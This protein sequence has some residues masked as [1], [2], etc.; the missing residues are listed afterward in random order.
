MISRGKK[1]MPD[2]CHRRHPFH[3]A[4]ALHLLRKL[5]VDISHIEI[6]AAGEYENY[7]GEV[8]SQEPAPETPLQKDTRIVLKVGYR[9]AVDLMPYQ[10]F[11]GL[12]GI[13]DR[14]SEWED[15]SRNL[16]A[17]FD[18]AFVRYFGATAYETLKFNFSFIDDEHLLRY[19]ELYDFAGVDI[20]DARTAER[21][22]SLMS[23][24]HIWAGNADMMGKV[25]GL[26]FGFEFKITES[27]PSRQQI[28]DS[29]QYKLGSKSG[30]LGQESIMGHSFVEC[31][32][33]YEVLIGIEDQ[34]NLRELLP[35]KSTRRKIEAVLDYCMPGNLDY[36]IKIKTREGQTTLGDKDKRGYLG[37][38]SYL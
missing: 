20:S 34:E 27:T 14:T 24:F 21:W 36:S 11:Y 9:S 4:T 15:K 30:R 1:I 10:F 25:L 33:G 12:A 35:G 6:L 28:P 23:T 13:T 17:P 38:N 22:L 8:R 29:L 16:M 2:L 32:T 26:L 18:A 37:Y 31:E 3:F 19:L 5:G 7:K